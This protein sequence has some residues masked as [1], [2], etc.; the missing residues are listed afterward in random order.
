M[1]EVYSGIRTIFKSPIRDYSKKYC[2]VGIPYDKTSTYRSGSRFGPSSIR[3]AST[4]LCDGVDA[5]FDID[6]MNLV[7]D[8][9][10]IEFDLKNN[11]LLNITHSNLILLGG[12]HSITYLG[13]QNVCNIVDDSVNLLHFD[14]HCDTWNTDE[15]EH[16]SFL[17]H[18]I[19]DS[20]VSTAIQYGIR[21]PL[22][23]EVKQWNKQH[24]ITGENIELEKQISN[25]S[26]WYVTIDIDSIDPSYAPGTG[27]PE[28]F[29]LTPHYVLDKLEEFMKVCKKNKAN[30]VGFDLV[31]VNPSYD[32]N[33]ITSILASNFIWK[34]IAMKEFYNV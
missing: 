2:V 30:I 28:S 27:T 8:Y 22:P 32:N 15:V 4:M 20:Y 33:Q 10:D 16:G 17:R 7:T 9:G 3:D 6:V 12:E 34:Y 23:K 1:S 24:I 31:E 5:K 13:L 26:N 14:A 25:N 21:S 29:G 18:A 19:D 11:K